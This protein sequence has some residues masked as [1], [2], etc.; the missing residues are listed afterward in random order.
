[1]SRAVILPIP[2]D[3]YI[4]KLWLTS[5][6]RYWGPDKGQLYAMINTPLE[7][8]VVDYTIKMF[9]DVGAKVFYKDRMMSHGPGITRL[10]NECQED[11]VF[12]AED[13]EKI[14]AAIREGW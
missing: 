8:P 5:W 6:E 12:I 1:M 7:H 13:R 10:I 11:V 3:P 2:G 4:A 14:V 9:E